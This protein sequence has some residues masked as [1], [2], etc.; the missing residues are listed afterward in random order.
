MIITIILM[1]QHFM[2]IGAKEWP[3]HWSESKL[4]CKLTDNDKARHLNIKEIS[5]IINIGT[6]I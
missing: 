5:T 3:C 1:Y 4:G 6:K 2:K